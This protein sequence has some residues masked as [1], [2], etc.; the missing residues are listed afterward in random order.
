MNQLHKLMEV[1]NNLSAP[2]YMMLVVALSLAA[3]NLVMDFSVPMLLATLF[4]VAIN[5][6]NDNCL[7]SGKCH[8]WA[9][10]V[11]SMYVLGLVSAHV[12]RAVG[13]KNKR[14]EPYIC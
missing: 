2:A 3:Y 4:S 14:Q 7:Y 12:L 5:V 1:V 10:V 11:A 13:K 8:T 6:Y 9:W